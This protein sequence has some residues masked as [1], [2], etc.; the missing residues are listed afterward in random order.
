MSGN[1]HPPDVIVSGKKTGD[2]TC[3]VLSADTLKPHHKIVGFVRVRRC[4][5]LTHAATE[6][7][8]KHAVI[9]CLEHRIDLVVRE[10]A[11]FRLGRE[12]DECVGEM[13]SIIL[14]NAE[15]T[16][17]ADPHILFRI[18]GYGVDYVIQ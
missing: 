11:V 9:L 17:V 8:Y 5:G 1:P 3:V 12:I 18:K 7:S 6:H 13:S 16:S 10:V 4:L 14:E 15:A 2:R